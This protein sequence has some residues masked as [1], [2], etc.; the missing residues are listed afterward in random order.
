MGLQT[1]KPLK[2]AIKPLGGVGVV[3]SA[4]QGERDEAG[5]LHGRESC[6]HPLLVPVCGCSLAACV[7]AA[8]CCISNCFINLRPAGAMPSPSCPLPDCLPPLCFLQ[9]TT[10]RWTPRWRRYTPPCARRTTRV[11]ADKLDCGG[12]MLAAPSSTHVRQH[13]MLTPPATALSFCK[14]SPSSRLSRSSPLD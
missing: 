3:K 5:A 10:S 14:Q 6:F 1:D 2:R 13:A 4:L 12:H 8:L 7:A 9:L 11:G